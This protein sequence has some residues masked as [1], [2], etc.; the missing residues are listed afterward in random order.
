MILGGYGRK[1]PEE[2]DKLALLCIEASMRTK[3]IVPQLT[4]RCY[5]GLNP[6]VYQKALESIAAGTT[7]P[8]LYSDDVNI[9]GIMNIFGLTRE[10][11]FEYVPLGCGEY[12]VNHSHICSPN[13]CL[14]LLEV[15]LTTIRGGIETIEGRQL[16]PDRG[17]LT[18]YQTFDD[19]WRAYTDNVEFFMKMTVA[20]VAR[21]YHL[22]A[23]ECSLNLVTPLY[24]DCLQ[25][26]KALLDGGARGVDASIEVY[27]LVNVSDSLL[28][29]KELI[30]EK[31]LIAPQTMLDALE[32]DF[33][34][35]EKE[36]RLMLQ[37]AKFGNDQKSADDMM[38]RVHENASFLALAQSGKYGMD[39][40]MIVNINNNVNTLWGRHTPASPDGRKC[41]TSMAN[42]NN[43]TAGMDK[44]GL[45]AFVN[46]LLKARTDIHAGAVQNFKFTHE[47]FDGSP[48]KAEQILKVYF[49]N[50]GAQAM[51][52]VV[53]R[54]EL[55][56]AR[57]NP[58]KYGNVIV[59]VG[60]FSARYI[61]LDDDVQLDILER[62]LY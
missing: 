58:E 47:M 51:V 53:G 43:P 46:S 56:N 24:D 19:L 20:Q 26:G 55:E 32:A 29:I 22:I 13:S 31:K 18:T 39:R 7:Y 61:E 15:L 30:Y 5:P 3:D 12:T 8:V 21:E 33:V 37:T 34:G 2:A 35:Y 10:E 45:T 50:G 48:S 49:D 44:N 54:E 9:P 27:G 41:G 52:S 4:L 40:Y 57:K 14:N 42:G 11:A 6:K 1:H 62:T 16:T 60:G 23:E 59:R 17:D 28:A 36:R 25:R 38:K